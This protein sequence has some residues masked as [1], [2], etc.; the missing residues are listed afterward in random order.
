MSNYLIDF[1][2]R[3]AIV[4]DMGDKEAKAKINYS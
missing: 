4:I 2:N 3:D 1:R